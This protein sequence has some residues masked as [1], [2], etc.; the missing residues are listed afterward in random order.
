M[1]SMK[2]I[3]IQRLRGQ[4]NEIEGYKILSSDGRIIFY[5]AIELRDLLVNGV[6]KVTNLTLASNHTI[7]YRNGKCTI[8]IMTK[9]FNGITSRE[10][11]S[12][13]FLDI[14]TLKPGEISNYYIGDPTDPKKPDKI[15]IRLL[16]EP[17]DLDSSYSG[18]YTLAIYSRDIIMYSRALNI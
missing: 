8:E 16:R 12:K 3:C 11:A 6:I 18:K 17:E 14:D 10:I 5:D 15:S 4:L 7:R 9:I 13:F 1:S 2:Y